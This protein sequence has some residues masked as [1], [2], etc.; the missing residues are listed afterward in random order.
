ME[1]CSCKQTT[2]G[3]VDI[4]WNLQ[5]SEVDVDVCINVSASPLC[6]GMDYELDFAFDTCEPFEPAFD[7]LIDF[8]FDN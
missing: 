7:Y 1:N 2:C 3:D 6:V 8:A 4:I 5:A